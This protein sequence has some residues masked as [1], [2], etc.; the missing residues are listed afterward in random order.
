MSK[1]EGA[2]ILELFPSSNPYFHDL[3]FFAEIKSTLRSRDLQ[4]F[5]DL[6]FFAIILVL[7]PNQYCG[8]YRLFKGLK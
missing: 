7:G 2:P 5:H 8:A 6:Y 3:V 4:E 1:L